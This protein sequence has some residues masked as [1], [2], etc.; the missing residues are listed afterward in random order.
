MKDIDE[1][2]NDGKGKSLEGTQ[3]YI[4]DALAVYIE[5]LREYQNFL[6]NPATST[7]RPFWCRNN[8]V[9]RGVVSETDIGNPF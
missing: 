9:H 7:L 1:V 5:D 8:K 4:Q 2:L 3:S 6:S